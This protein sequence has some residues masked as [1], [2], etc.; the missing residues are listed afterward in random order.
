MSI[1]GKRLESFIEGCNATAYTETPDSLK[2]HSEIARSAWDKIKWALAPL[3]GKTVL[4]IGCAN[5]FA[6]EMFT[7]DGIDRADYTGITCSEADARDCGARGV[8][9]ILQLD[10]HDLAVLEDEDNRFDLVWARHVLEHTPV[11]LFVLQG[12]HLILRPGTGKLYV[13]VPAPDTACLH[14]TNPNHFSC[15]SR[16]GWMGLF[17]KAGFVPMEAF[18]IQVKVPAGDDRYFC[19]LLGLK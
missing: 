6:Q 16:E 8:P 18:D 11:P 17:D 9:N 5:G 13:E 4:D 15:F 10:M 12:I 19:W 7:A 14:T 3:K 2:F 1:L